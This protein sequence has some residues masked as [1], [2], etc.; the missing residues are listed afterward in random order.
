MSGKYTAIFTA[1][2]ILSATSLAQAQQS[3]S[4]TTRPDS[5]RARD[6]DQ[7]ALTTDT[8][9]LHHDVALRDSARAILHQDQVQTR[10]V[11]TQIDSLQAVLQHDRQ[12]TPRDD[13]AIARDKAAVKRLRGKLDSDLDRARRERA[14]VDLARKAVDH[15]R[16]A[17]IEAH[18]DIREDKPKPQEH[19]GAAKK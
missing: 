4:D 7:R 16:D 15:E 10:G 6:R 1:F 18:H 17:A 19:S 9:K 14:R 2:L 8:M 13:A 11:E 5:D 3:T 12:A